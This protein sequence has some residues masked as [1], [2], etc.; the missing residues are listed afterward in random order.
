ML[1][2]TQHCRGGP[3]LVP[4]KLL[5]NARKETSARAE[6]WSKDPDTG[7]VAKLVDLVEQ[8]YY[9]KPQRDRLEVGRPPNLLCYSRIHCNV[10]RCV[11]LVGKAGALAASI[12]Q[13][14]GE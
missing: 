6:L 2:A 11:I 13:V 8:V 14:S 3:V 1:F 7:A 12:I 5:R 10:W 9:V 4:S